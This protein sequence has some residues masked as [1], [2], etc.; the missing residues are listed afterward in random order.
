MSLRELYQQHGVTITESEEESIL[1][2]DAKFASRGLDGF[3]EKFLFALLPQTLDA[4]PHPNCEDGLVM[5]D[6]GFRRVCQDKWH[7]KE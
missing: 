5:T 2:L 3:A 7:G 6:T 1:A 4:C